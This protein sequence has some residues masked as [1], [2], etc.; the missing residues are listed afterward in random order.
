MSADT[1]NNRMSVMDAFFLYFEKPHAPLHIGSV[2]VFEGTIPLDDTRDGLVSRLHLIPRYRQ[3]PVFPPFFAGHPTWEDDPD[4][5]IGR[6]LRL[7]DEPQPVSDRRLEE[8]VAELFAQPLPRD[9]PL[10]EITVVQGLEGD[11]TAYISRVHHCMVDGVSGVELLLAL[12][13]VSPVVPEPQEPPLW[14][15]KPLPSRASSFL[16]ATLD[17]WTEGAVAIGEWVKQLID[18]R[19]ALGVASR[20]TNAL[21]AAVSSAMRPA[22][23]MF[24]NRQIGKKRQF[25]FVSMPFQEVRGIRSELK[26]TV[27]DVVLSI[28]AGALRRYLQEHS[29]T[30]DERTLRLMIPVNVRNEAQ[31]GDLGNRVSMMLPELPV[32][33]ED[34]LA[35]LTAVREE[36]DRLKSDK[37]GA[38]FSALIKLADPAPAVLPVLVGMAGVPSGMLNLVCTNVPGPL[39]PLYAAG[40][41]LLTSWPLLPLAGDLGLGVAITSYNEHLYWGIV[42]DPD[43]VPD[44]W[45][46]GGLVDDE[47]QNL[48]NAAGVTV[49]EPA[50]IMPVGERLAQADAKLARAEAT[51]APAS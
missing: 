47:F 37:Q 45:R 35:R 11:R 13:D 12:L 5:D 9:R 4:F 49:S 36:I 41:R 7:I 18:P 15:P 14:E 22:S 20:L 26:C 25:S 48:R 42:C 51:K 23:P 10:W 30:V 39:L 16:N 50:G 2:G 6:H 3:K 44:V 24:W 43:L 32:G 19:L 38:S 17:T 33:I 1:T 31:Q 21:E 29:V 8:I 27:N 40:H 34:P 28:L 46:L